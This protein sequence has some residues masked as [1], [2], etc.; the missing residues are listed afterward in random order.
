MPLVNYKLLYLEKVNSLE[1]DFSDQIRSH[2]EEVMLRLK[3][4][5]KLNDLHSLQRD[6]ESKYKRALEELADQETVS[7]R[8]GETILKLETQ[9]Q[10]HKSESIRKETIITSLENQVKALEERIQR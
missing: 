6:I 2:E 8:T 5:K 3:F 9:V 4:E 10:I 7:K 1:K